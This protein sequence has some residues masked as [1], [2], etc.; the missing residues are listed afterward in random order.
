MSILGQLFLCQSLLLLR[1]L[2]LHLLLVELVLGQLLVLL[3][4]VLRYIVVPL[5]LWDLDLDLDMASPL[6]AVITRYLTDLKVNV[7]R[8]LGLCVLSTLMFNVLV[9]CVQDVGGGLL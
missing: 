5:A 4:S 6:V 3:L 2:L 1:L 8:R 9:N 7:L